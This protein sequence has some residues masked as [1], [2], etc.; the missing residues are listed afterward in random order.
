MT[1]ALKV[2]VWTGFTPRGFSDRLKN[3]SYMMAAPTKK[4]VYETTGKK[5]HD[6]YTVN[7]VGNDYRNNNRAEEAPNLF[8]VALENPGQVFILD[9]DAHGNRHAPRENAY[10]PVSPEEAW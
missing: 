8:A 2:Y 5:A 6:H 1:R 10:A 7:E 9:Y 3:C 4:A